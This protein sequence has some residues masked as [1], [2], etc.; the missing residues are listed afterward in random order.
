MGVDN[1][2]LDYD[3]VGADAAKLEIRKKLL[4]VPCTPPF[5]FRVACGDKGY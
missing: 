4:A 1:V 5:N 3:T 2:L